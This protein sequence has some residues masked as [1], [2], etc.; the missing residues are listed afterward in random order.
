[1]TYLSIV[2]NCSVIFKMIQDAAVKVGVDQ[3]GFDA[4]LAQFNE[5]TLKQFKI[6]REKT[7]GVDM[8]TL[9]IRLLPIGDEG[10]RGRRTIDDVKDMTRDELTAFNHLHMLVYFKII[11]MKLL[12]IFISISRV[13]HRNLILRSSKDSML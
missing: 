8:G 11:L 13:Y 6:V 10:S 4:A 7:L 9:L 1:M 3:Y 2:E 5:L 12:R